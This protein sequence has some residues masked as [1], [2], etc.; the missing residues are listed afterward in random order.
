MERRAAACTAKSLLYHLFCLYLSLN[1]LCFQSKNET[2][3][4]SRNHLIKIIQLQFCNGFFAVFWR[5]FLSVKCSIYLEG[6]I[7]QSQC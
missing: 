6:C 7:L 3:S 4:R 1:L 5:S 2:S